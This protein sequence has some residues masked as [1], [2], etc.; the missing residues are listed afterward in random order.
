MP[1]GLTDDLKLFLAEMTELLEVMEDGLL[2]LEKAPDPDVVAETFRAAH[3]LKGSSAT[4]GFSGMAQVTHA[5]EDLLD[6]WRDGAMP[7]SDQRDLLFDGLDW[8]NEAKKKLED[9]GACP[10]GDNLVARIRGVDGYGNGK[11]QDDRVSHGPA[12]NAAQLTA[13]VPWSTVQN[14]LAEAVTRGYRAFQVHIE[15]DQA[16]VMPSVR[17]FQVCSLLEDMGKVPWSDP[18]PEQIERD[19]AGATLDVIVLTDRD[20]DEITRAIHSVTDVVNAGVTELKIQAKAAPA[21]PKAGGRVLG[22]SVRLDVEVLDTLMNLIGELIVDRTRLAQVTGKI[23]EATDL[24]EFERN[25]NGISAHIARI[26]TQLQEGIMRARLVPLQNLVRKYPRLVRDLASSFK[27]EVNFEIQ[28]EQTELDRSVIEAI[29]DPLIHILRNAV[30]HGIETPGERSRAGKPKTGTVR[31]IAAHHENQVVITITDD[32]KGIDPE[33]LRTAA[34]RKG[35]MTEETA[36]RLNDEQALELIFLPGFS[37]KERVSEV[38]GRGVG[39]DVV[40]TNLKKING[41][42][43]IKSRPGG[44]TTFILRLPLTLAIIQALLVRA[45]KNVYSIPLSMVSEA[46]K[47]EPSNMST[48]HGKPVIRVRDRIFPLVDLDGLFFNGGSFGRDYAVI[49]VDYGVQIAIAVDSLLGQQEIVVKNLGKFFGGV[50]GI[51]GATILGDGSLALIV[52]VSRLVMSHADENVE[53]YRE[54]AS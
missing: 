40:R 26:S 32:G 2:K 18:S 19:E 21:Q 20:A 27:K 43:D 17:A 44:G 41:T 48:V 30:D 6:T 4:I 1:A 25:L 15:F 52:D 39:M 9:G 16:A 34:V 24:E 23:Q 54:A 46:V 36:R 50:K 49:T 31:L 22:S 29:D 51:S 45:G 47:V 14:E 38:S 3:T 35:F 42:V 13:S 33:S 37:T 10:E 7:T 11:A 12:G 5:M 28:G 53:M 8:L